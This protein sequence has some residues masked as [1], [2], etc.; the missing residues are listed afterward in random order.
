VLG[1][2]SSRTSTGG[3]TL[4]GFTGRLLKDLLLVKALL[5]L[6]LLVGPVE[7]R[8]AEE[9]L[10]RPTHGSNRPGARTRHA[11]E[12]ASIHGRPV[13]D[14]G[15]LLV[16]S[17]VRGDRHDGVDTCRRHETDQLDSPGRL[18][19]TPLWRK[20]INLFNSFWISQNSS[21][22]FMDVF[23]VSQCV[24]VCYLRAALCECVQVCYLQAAP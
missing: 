17:R 20:E 19:L 12:E 6:L 4:T 1:L 13:H 9:E 10:Q 18:R 2:G 8:P 24:Q 23:S 14:H 3:L 15:V 11:P 21:H 7:H 16:V 22:V 5:R